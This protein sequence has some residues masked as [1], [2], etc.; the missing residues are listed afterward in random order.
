MEL[1]PKQKGR[2]EMRLVVAVGFSF[3]V[4]E[5]G[6]NAFIAL[7][8]R[9]VRVRNVDAEA[10]GVSLFQ[11][12]RQDMLCGEEDLINITVGSSCEAG[13]DIGCESSGLFLRGAESELPV[14]HPVTIDRTGFSGAIRKNHIIVVVLIVAD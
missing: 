3:R 13:R 12:N 6:K 14:D 9:I 4:G 8:L 10:E 7:F 2:P 1:F 11:L 5:G